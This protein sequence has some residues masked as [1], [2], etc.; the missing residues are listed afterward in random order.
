MKTEFDINTTE[1]ARS[2]LESE[3]LDVNKI[4]KEGLDFIETV[5]SKI[6]LK[7][8]IKEDLIKKH[9]ENWHGLGLYSIEH[10]AKTGKASGTFL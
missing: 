8:K 7:N 2:Y 3:G 1:G 6:A 5:K 4:V 9:L 10:F